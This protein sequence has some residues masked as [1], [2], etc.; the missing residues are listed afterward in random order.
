MQ[1]LEKEKRPLLTDDLELD[2]LVG[3][4][5]LYLKSSDISSPWQKLSYSRRHVGRIGEVVS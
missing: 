2:G 3:C 1:M 4:I 5:V